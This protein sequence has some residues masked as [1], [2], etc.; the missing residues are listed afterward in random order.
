MPTP[1]QQA[2][3]DLL[4]PD[5]GDAEVADVGSFLDK[6][7]HESGADRG[8]LENLFDVKGAKIQLPFCEAVNAVTGTSEVTEDDS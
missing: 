4:E 2:S 8:T 6:L 1:N 7:A 3:H 5:Q